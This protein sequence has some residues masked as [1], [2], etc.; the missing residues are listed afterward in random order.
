MKDSAQ[1]VVWRETAGRHA[2][3]ATGYAHAVTGDQ[4]L[5]GMPATTAPWQDTGRGARCAECTTAVSESP[6]GYQEIMEGVGVSYRRLHYWT[7]QGWVKALNPECGSGR[8]LVWPAEEVRVVQVMALLVRSGVE[9]GAAAKAARNG[10]V[11]DD[12]V[13]VVV[14]TGGVRLGNTSL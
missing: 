12:G 1:G 5:C 8:Q 7:R 2:D 9:P 13:R 14:D 6:V 11:L 4:T 3:P 10:G